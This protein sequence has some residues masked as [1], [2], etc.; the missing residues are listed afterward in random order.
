MFSDITLDDFSTV[1]KDFSGVYALY[2]NKDAKLDIFIAEAAEQMEASIK[3]NKP[4]YIGSSEHVYRRIYA[5]HLQG[6]GASTLRKTIYELCDHS[7]I[8]ELNTTL[9]MNEIINNWLCENTYFKTCPTKEY[10]ALEY[11][12]IYKHNPV[13]NN[14]RKK[15]KNYRYN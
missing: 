15:F 14:G 8:F 4:V 12:L 11:M 1:P 7:K 13:F 2:L 10:C 6:V 5:N 9:K 3:E